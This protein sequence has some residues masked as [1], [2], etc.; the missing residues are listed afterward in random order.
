VIEEVAFD[1]F[2]FLIV[3][4]SLAAEKDGIAMTRD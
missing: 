1:A 2:C 3:F 4:V